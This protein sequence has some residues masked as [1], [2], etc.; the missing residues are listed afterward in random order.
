MLQNNIKTDYVIKNSVGA[1]WMK[2][3]RNFPMKKVEEN[4]RNWWQTDCVESKASS[5]QSCKNR[6]AYHNFNT[7]V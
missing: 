4:I 5:N 7:Y 2:V 1:K 3:K 6:V